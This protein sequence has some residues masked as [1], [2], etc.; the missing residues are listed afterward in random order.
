MQY[1]KKF[2][3][4][5]KN[6]RRISVALR[7]F[8]IKNMLSKNQIKFI[9][10][11]E[12]KK[13]R[14]EYGLFLAEGGKSVC[15]L[16]HSGNECEYIVATKEW[17]AEN[18]LPK[19][20]NIIEVSNEELNRITLLRT[21]QGV[22]GVFKQRNTTIDANITQ[23][24]LCLALDDIQDPGNLGTI[25]R[26]ADWFGIEHIFCSQGTADVYNPKTVQATMG[27]IGR[28]NINYVNLPQ[29]L[30]SLKGKAPIYGTFL[31]GK[32]IYE[33][34]LTKN[35]IIVM[36]NEGNGIGKECAAH[37]DERLLIPSYP[38]ERPT[39]ESLNVSTATAIICAEFRRR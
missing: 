13:F 25:I 31:N 4:R 24:E 36:G 16:I 33:K 15:D 14:K 38:A 37:I 30:E 29:L 23:T 22:A 8:Y 32:N 7:Y 26:I 9:R 5:Y 1:T 10:S 2:L 12:Q 17:L 28:V 34:E 21:P 19:S 35:G 39:S 27:A 18:E 11:L 20:T 6:P 3:Q